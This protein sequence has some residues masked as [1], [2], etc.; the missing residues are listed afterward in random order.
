M[1]LLMHLFLLAIRMLK[2]VLIKLL[3][4]KDAETQVDLVK[5]YTDS[6][7]NTDGIFVSAADFQDSIEILAGL[8]D[9]L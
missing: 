1:L 6:S 9:Y 5:T 2:Q 8:T 4:L 7:T 3:F